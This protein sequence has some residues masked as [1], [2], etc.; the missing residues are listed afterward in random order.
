LAA[1]TSLSLASLDFEGI[2]TAQK[3]FMQSQSA[4]KDYNFDGS[5]MRALLAVQAY[6][7]YLMSFY[8]NMVAAE[9]FNDSAQLRDSIVSHAKELN[10][11]PRSAKSA[12]TNLN[13]TF[14]TSGISTL[15]VPKGTQFSGLNTTGNHKFVTD[16]NNIYKSSNNFFAITDLA[17]YE[18]SYFK[19][20]YVVDTASETQRFVLS[21]KNI[22]V[23]S[24]T[25]TVNDGI[26]N[27][28]YLQATTL[29]SI[30]ADSKIFFLEA[31]SDYRYE[32]KFGN[33]I[34]GFSPI[35]GAVITAEYRV[36]T[37]AD[38]NGMKTFIL[39]SELGTPNGGTVLS[40]LTISASSTTEGGAAAE[41]LESIR[42]M[43]PRHYQTQSRAIIPE[44]YE[45]LITEA[46]P[47]VKSVHV[48]GGEEID[49][50][51]EY[52]RVYIVASSISGNPISNVDKS[53]I[54]AYV[55]NKNSLGIQ[56]ILIDPDYLALKLYIN[57]HVNLNNTNL[58]IPMIKTL[59]ASGVAYFNNTH[60]QRFHSAFRFSKFV[61]Y[62]NTLDPSIISNEVT[63]RLQ[64]NISPP[65]NVIYSNS[66]S[67]LNKI[68]PGI[69]SSYF[70]AKAKEWYFTDTVQGIT[71]PGSNLYLV[72]NNP[73]NATP[74]YTVMGSINYE[75]GLLNIN[76]LEITDFLGH[77]GVV[78]TVIPA[79]QDVY[80][81]A[82]NILEIDV[83]N[84]TVD[85]TS[86]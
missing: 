28:V 34:F 3:T 75:T 65:L 6:N 11:L 70:V 26:S 5:N 83:L 86:E 31:T 18:G 40:P 61:T 30:G 35:H 50:S 63:V 81:K 71:N 46:F 72:E 53:S 58:T 14:P 85:V 37:G 52:G 12:T 19:E 16:R 13:L 48:Y 62:L 17:V 27:I 9:R 15:E 33:G 64:K 54:K 1:N 76:A 59:I 42:Y 29:Y 32:L 38:G 69:I 20:S 22:D 7:T 2:L 24:I 66:V 39:D 4:F 47:N 80:S 21:N 60:L 68:L 84:F 51:V 77:N 36:C 73:N 56:P 55:S 49:G 74:N 25:V 67:F 79:N 82:N 78:F 43:S 44:D 41:T 23:A 45:T 8:Y 10:Y 57:T